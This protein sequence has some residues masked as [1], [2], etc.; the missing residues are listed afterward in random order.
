[1][2][3][4]HLTINSANQQATDRR[5]A[6]WT[7][8]LLADRAF[9]SEQVTQLDREVTLSPVLAQDAIATTLRRNAC[10]ALR[11]ID[12]ALARLAT[13]RFGQCVSCG[14]SM[15]PVRLDV[16]PMAALC[17]SCQYNIESST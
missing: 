12:D 9:R 1:M 10:A 17:M 13:G 6:T 15:D 16:L 14:Q 2:S 3:R 4:A 7:S 5:R 8:R 11:E